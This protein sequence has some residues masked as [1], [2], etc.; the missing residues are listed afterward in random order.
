MHLASQIR[1]R[2][3][4]ALGSLL[5]LLVLVG[6]IGALCPSAEA[7]GPNPANRDTPFN[8]AAA[9]QG[10][11]GGHVVTLGLGR[12]QQ[13]GALGLPQAPVFHPYHPAGDDPDAGPAVHARINQGYVS[14]PFAAELDPA[15][16]ANLPQSV[17]AALVAENINPANVD[18]NI[19]EQNM[20]W[21]PDTVILFRPHYWTDPAALTFGA[22]NN[23]TQVRVGFFHPDR[24]L[25]IAGQAPGTIGPYGISVHPGQAVNPPADTRTPIVS[26][27]ENMPVP[28][29][30]SRESSS[31]WSVVREGGRAAVTLHLVL[32]DNDHGTF[33]NFMAT[34]L[35]L[36]ELTQQM[37]AAGSQVAGRAWVAKLTGLIQGAGRGDVT[38]AEPAP[39]P[40]P[41]GWQQATV[42]SPQS[43]G[44]QAV[45]L[46]NRGMLMV[47]NT[48]DRN[49]I[50]LGRYN[51]ANRT[52]QF[53]QIGSANCNGQSLA[54]V[55]HGDTFHIFATGHQA[56]QS[57]VCHLS[58]LNGVDWREEH[59]DVGQSSGLGLSATIYQGR[60]NLA[61]RGNETAPGSGVYQVRQVFQSPQGWRS[62][63]IA[64]DASATS[65]TAIGVYGDQLHAMYETVIHELNHLWYAPAPVGVWA[66]EIVAREVA[67]DTAMNISTYSEQFHLNYEARGQ[68]IHRFYDPGAGW[69]Q[70]T[71]AADILPGSNI[72]TATYGNQYHL[73]YGAA[74]NRLAHRW[75]DAT[76]G[77]WY[78]ETLDNGNVTA[79]GGLAMVE[80]NG[81][82]HILT[83]TP[84]NELR[85]L[86]YQ[87]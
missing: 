43:T 57:S 72:A 19:V 21:T 56:G 85:H 26:S 14:T 61:N 31:V 5:T 27:P 58:S 1:Q 83:T 54:G 82:F 40:R 65:N 46:Q 24:G 84:T 68:I 86:N 32:D 20:P 36:I 11:D 15:Y 59:L 25:T 34:S 12:T 69:V 3:K 53:Q 7:V 8:I 70:E 62:A 80:Y 77:R 49:G 38:R 63:T 18:I 2:F 81:N 79:I 73:V 23:V 47:A 10:L 13:Y 55:V 45:V 16:F 33:Q 42:D 44:S 6:G 29:L 39:G 67:A 37:N 76:T 60:I 52:W 9:P 4:F 74:G 51:Q 75:Y 66:N 64:D 28:G 48:S 71:V 87:P 41:S 50:R 78:D 30:N 35:N 17:V 22:Y